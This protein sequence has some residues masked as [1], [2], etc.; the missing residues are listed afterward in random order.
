METTENGLLRKLISFL[1]PMNRRMDSAVR[2]VIALG[3]LTI[4]LAIVFH[5]VGRYFVGRTYMGTMELIRYVMVWVSLLGASSAFVS[6]DHVA[7]NILGNYL[8]ANAWN[9]TKIAGNLLLGTFMVAMIVGGMEIGLRN[10]NQTSMGLRI[11]MFFPY[12][13]IPVGALL[14]LPHIL[15]NILKAMARIEE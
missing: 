2:I 11:P 3:M 12:L 14:A 7:I 9:R 6:S 10:W 8:S 15:L 1:E 5:V 4:M 13:A